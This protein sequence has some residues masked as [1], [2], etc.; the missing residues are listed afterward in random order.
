M[1]DTFV[2]KVRTV[3]V[4]MVFISDKRRMMLTSRRKNILSGQP[5]DQNQQKYKDNYA[6]V[7]SREQII[8][9]SVDTPVMSNY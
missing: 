5:F 8:Q 4:V 9:I 7:M 2:V 6:Q 1:L 3:F